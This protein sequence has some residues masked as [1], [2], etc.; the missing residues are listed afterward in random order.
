[1]APDRTRFCDLCSQ[2]IKPRGW[3][4]HRKAC[5]TN[6][7][8]RCRDQ[9][10]LKI[11]LVIQQ[12][13]LCLMD[14]GQLDPVAL[15]HQARDHQHDFAHGLDVDFGL[16]N[17]L[18]PELVDAAALPTY[19][20]D[21]IKV[22]Y[23]PNSGIEMKVH[24][25]DNFHRRPAASSVHTPP[26]N[27]PW[28]P[29]QSRLKFDVAELALEA[30][31]N[32]K[33]TDH[34]IKICHHNSVGKEKF[35]FRNHKDIHSKWEAASHRITK[36]MK[37]VIS[38]PYDGKM[39]DFDVHYRDLWELATD[40]LRDPRLFPHFTFDAQRLSK[41]DGQTFIRFIDE[42][43]TA[44]DFWDVQSQLPPDA[45][46]LAVK[47]VLKGEVTQRASASACTL[48]PL[49]EYVPFNFQGTE[50]KSNGSLG[51]SEGLSVG[52]VRQNSGR[53]IRGRSKATTEVRSR[54]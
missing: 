46:P 44:Q 5:K 10:I 14:D 43:F 31:L 3:T 40:L 52:G 17:P 54:N 41:F 49:P 28:R 33:Q 21:D 24:A 39:W 48:R 45:K 20:R 25:F 19:S 2:D 11:S 34:L 50:G 26:D 23:H 27:Q 36:F 8:K 4:T 18:E 35:T 13:T 30:G 38:V 42:P 15:T 47:V 53:F 37:E 12:R 7:E 22:E 32:N 16:I 29:F 6:T 1:M 51:S 9:V